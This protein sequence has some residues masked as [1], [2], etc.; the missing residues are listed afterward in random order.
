MSS[1]TYSPRPTV[2]PD[3]PTSSESSDGAVGTHPE[4]AAH[5][6][7]GTAFW[8]AHRAKI[9]DAALATRHTPTNQ[10]ED[11]GNPSPNVQD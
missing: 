11:R 8:E 1:S 9:E 3:T 7:Q 4:S 6:D 2:T 10:D 5:Y